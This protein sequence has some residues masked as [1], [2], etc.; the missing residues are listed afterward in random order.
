VGSRAGLDAAVLK[1]KI[2]YPY[3]KS[4]PG[5]PARC[6]VTILIELP[7]LHEDVSLA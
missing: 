1:I 2:P 5:R 7:R 6:S 3:R 4:N